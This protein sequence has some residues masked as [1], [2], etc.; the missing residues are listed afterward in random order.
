MLDQLSHYDPTF[1][2][3][4]EVGPFVDTSFTR[5]LKVE[6]QTSLINQ[7][8]RMDSHPLNY[9]LFQRPVLLVHLDR[10]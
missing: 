2:L 4:E 1:I 3:V 10:L 9:S 7:R 5:P 6:W 8:V